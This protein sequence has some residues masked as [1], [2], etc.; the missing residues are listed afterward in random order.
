M[1]FIVPF[2]FLELLG[3]C[4]SDSVAHNAAARRA[5]TS[6]AEKSAVQNQMN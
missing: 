4:H 1:R 6:D 5:T 2:L 3:A